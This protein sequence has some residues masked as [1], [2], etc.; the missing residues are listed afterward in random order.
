MSKYN[1]LL[2]SIISLNLS[3]QNQ[4]KEI[5]LNELDLSNKFQLIIKDIVKVEKECDYYKDDLFFSI[6]Y[7]DNKISF[8]SYKELEL[9]LDDLTYGYVCEDNHLFFVNSPIPDNFFNHTNTK[10]SFMISSKEDFEDIYA[11]DGYFSFWEFSLEKNDI[12]LKSK[13]LSCEKKN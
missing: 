2:L 8:E 5:V 10:K 3:A 6:Q 12:L 1:L 4:S 11:L 13:Y 9:V 7:A